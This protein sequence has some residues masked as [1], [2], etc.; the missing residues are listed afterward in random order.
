MRKTG[1]LTDNHVF[2]AALSLLLALLILT[3]LLLI[4]GYSPIE[5]YR[6][7]FY[8]AFGNWGNIAM[9]LGTATPLILA[10]LSMSVAAKSG[11]FNI[12]CEGQIIAG[13][14]VAALVGIYCTGLPKILHILVCFAAA[15][16]VGGLC[17]ALIA[18]LK[19]MLNVSEL[20]IAIMLNY[21]IKY[22]TDYLLVYH[23]KIEGMVIRTD[24][25]A[26]TAN[27][28]QLAKLSRLNTGFFLVII[29]VVLAEVLLR[30][31]VTGYE[32]RACGYNRYAAETAGINLRTMSYLGMFI[33]GAISAIGGAI[34]VMGFHRYFM[35]DITTGYGFTG[36]AVGIMGGSTPI[37]SFIS[38]LIF[39]A[40]RAGSTNMNR[41]TMIPSEFI[42]VLQG[43]VIVFIATPRITKALLNVG[44]LFHRRGGEAHE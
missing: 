6:A 12:G 40:L 8:G 15:I 17:G 36:V 39:G 14:F 7:L 31:S 33:S 42:S 18:F 43:L 5:G 10:G 19:R 16:L 22:V 13:A 27:L 37:G 24:E 25:I 30:K 9:T 44:H 34:E 11:T 32:M 21:I 41:A 38:G 35:T 23:F 3:L 28:T 26:K 20:I 29:L 1:K 2:L 4:M